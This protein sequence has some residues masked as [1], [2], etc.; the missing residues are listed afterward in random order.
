ML[1]YNNVGFSTSVSLNGLHDLQ[2][3]GIGLVFSQPIDKH[4]NVGIFKQLWW[5]FW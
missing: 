4:I 1:R 3:F 5:F 2:Y